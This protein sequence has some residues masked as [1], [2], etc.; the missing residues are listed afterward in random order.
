MYVCMIYVCINLLPILDKLCWKK[1]T[2]P[3]GISVTRCKAK[4]K[5]RAKCALCTLCVF[6]SLW[7]Y[8]KTW[9]FPGK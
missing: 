8:T 4:A 9:Q 5:Y 3:V 1:F 6:S 7:I 2:F